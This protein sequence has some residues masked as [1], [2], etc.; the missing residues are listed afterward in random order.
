[1]DELSNI[2]SWINIERDI[3][4]DGANEM[5]HRTIIVIR[6][7]SD[8]YTIASMKNHKGWWLTYDPEKKLLVSSD[9]KRRFN[10]DGSVIGDKPKK[11]LTIHSYTFKD[12]VLM[13]ELNN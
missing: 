6:T 12:G 1:L 7:G 13:V 3:P 5:I 10:V 4:T 8:Y 9:G 11:S 2:G